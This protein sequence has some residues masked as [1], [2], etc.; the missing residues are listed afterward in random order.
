MPDLD[1]R[2]RD[3]YWIYQ[4]K[5]HQ[6]LELRTLFMLGGAQLG[7]ISSLLVGRGIVG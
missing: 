6:S 2:N 3:K 7:F 1:S 5:R 4:T